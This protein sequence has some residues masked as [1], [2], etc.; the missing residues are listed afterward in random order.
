[1]IKPIRKEAIKDMLARLEHRQDL[2]LAKCCRSLV[3]EN[4]LSRETAQAMVNRWAGLVERIKDVDNP[5]WQGL[6]AEFGAWCSAQAVPFEVVMAHLHTYR[7]LAM[8]LLVREYPGV[9]G[10]LEAHLALDEALTLLMGKIPAGY[11]GAS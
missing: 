6:A 11:Y 4:G 3:E 8:P 7:R 5:A 9:E 10:Y 2:L 1:L